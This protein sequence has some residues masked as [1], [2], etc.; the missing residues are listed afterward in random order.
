MER[1][2]ASHPAASKGRRRFR[3]QGLVE[4]ALILPVLLILLFVIIELARVLHAWLAIENGARFGARYAVTG[5]YDGSYCLDTDASGTPCDAQSEE[6]A[7]RI[8]SIKDAARAGAV[9][10]LRNETVA[11]EVRAI[12]ISRY[13]R[14]GQ[15]RQSCTALLAATPTPHRGQLAVRLRSGRGRRRAGRPRRGDRRFRASARSCR[16]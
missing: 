12:S 1:L 9:A 3:G 8:P 14:L 13:A 11:S 4:F 16:S 7:A 6:D 2:P 15:D 10:I 5:E